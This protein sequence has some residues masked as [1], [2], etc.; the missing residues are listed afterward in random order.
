MFW[1]HPGSWRYPNFST[2]LI[3]FPPK[4][5]LFSGWHRGLC[6]ARDFQPCPACVWWRSRDTDGPAGKVSWRSSRHTSSGWSC[7]GR[8]SWE[9][10]G[11][12]GGWWGGPGGR[13]GGPGPAGRS[14]RRWRG[15]RGRW[16]LW[17]RPPGWRS[18][19]PGLRQSSSPPAETPANSRTPR[20]PGSPLAWPGRHP[21]N[22]RRGLGLGKLG[23]LLNISTGYVLHI[24]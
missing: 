1:W 17:G 2:L 21:A 14:A 22:S 23:K 11:R 19:S 3:Y 24:E 15:T 20:T 4:N 18:S 13:G 16:R 7:P 12:G 6:T 9:S 10:A 8:T 5:C